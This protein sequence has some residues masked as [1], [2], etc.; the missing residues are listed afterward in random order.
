MVLK[1]LLVASLVTIITGYDRNIMI[2]DLFLCK[3]LLLEGDYVVQSYPITTLS[4]NNVDE[5]E[6]IHMKFYVLGHDMHVRLSNSQDLDNPHYIA[7]FHGN[8]GTKHTY[9]SGIA[10][11][12]Q[13]HNSWNLLTSTLTADLTDRFY[14]TMMHL[15]VTKSGY[16]RF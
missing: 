16:S 5:N 4:N 15:V 3:E 7:Y 13:K 11:T 8:G 12:E 10:V 14:Y 9:T 1:S 2:A 6:L